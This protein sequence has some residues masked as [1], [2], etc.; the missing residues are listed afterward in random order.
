MGLLLNERDNQVVFQLQFLILMH[1]MLIASKYR[2]VARTH[3]ITH[4]Q[5]YINICIMSIC[6][7]P[8][9]CISFLSPGHFTLCEPL[10]KVDSIKTIGITGNGG[11]STGGIVLQMCPIKTVNKH[12]F[13]SRII[14]Y[15]LPTRC[16]C[17]PDVKMNDTL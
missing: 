7:Y 8:Q 5:M 9:T 14:N 16:N 12:N 15:Q 6:R 17:K 2:K 11:V 1:H 3:T 10:D 13:L 4:K